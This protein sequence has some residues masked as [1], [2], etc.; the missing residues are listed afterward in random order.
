MQTAP[1]MA[2]HANAFASFINPSLSYSQYLR[3]VHVN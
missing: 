3:S 2:N 1:A